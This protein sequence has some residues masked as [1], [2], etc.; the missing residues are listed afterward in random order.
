MGKK[1]I[2]IAEDHTILRKV[3]RS[4]F[5][6]GEELKVAGEVE[7]GLEAIRRVEG[8]RPDLI[9]LDLAMPRM[10]GTKRS[11]KSIGDRRKRTSLY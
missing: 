10:S 11:G 6:S 8:C 4:L 9:L 7:Q 3:L 5:S 2:V 1:R